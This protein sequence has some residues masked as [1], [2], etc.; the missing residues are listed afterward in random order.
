[1]ASPPGAHSARMGPPGKSS[2]APVLVSSTAADSQDRRI[3]RPSAD[4]RNLLGGVEYDGMFVTPRGM[5]NRDWT[6]LAATSTRA[7]DILS[8]AAGPGTTVRT[9]ICFPSGD[10]AGCQR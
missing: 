6:F 9:A 1:M 2:K 4:Q 5:P 8:G 7:I 3:L 10:H